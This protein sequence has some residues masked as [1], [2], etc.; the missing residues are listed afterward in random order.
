MEETGG[1]VVQTTFQK[2]VARLGG[3]Q[4][5]KAQEETHT[6]WQVLVYDTQARFYM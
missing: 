4:G 1:R 2:G 3:E 5:A 6:S